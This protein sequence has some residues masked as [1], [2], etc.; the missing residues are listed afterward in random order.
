ME[1][2][3]TGF[4]PQFDT[5][6]SVEVAK[7]R[8]RQLQ[9][10]QRQSSSNQRESEKQ[11]NQTRAQARERTPAQSSVDNS[12]IINGEV[13]SSETVRVNTRESFRELN[14]EASGTA[15]FRNPNQQSP[16]SGQPSNRRI[17][18]EQAIQTFRDNQELVL[19]ESTPRQVSG[20]IDEFV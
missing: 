12:R 20:I 10:A 13:L 1:I 11:R 17:P 8:Q 4:N 9:D 7:Q 16:T 19:D 14:K 2:A 6:T 18:V 5:S 3:L 15:Q